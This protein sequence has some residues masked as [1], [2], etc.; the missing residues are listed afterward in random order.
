LAACG[1]DRLGVQ[2]RK[3]ESGQRYLV[4][5]IL[6][7]DLAHFELSENRTGPNPDAGI[8]ITPM[9]DRAGYGRYAGP[10]A[11]GFSVSGTTIET[12]EMRISVEDDARSV[13]VF[14]KVRGVPLTR[15]SG[16]DLDQGTKRLRIERQEIENVYGVGNLFYDPNMA[17]GDWVGRNWQGR[18]HGN[19]RFGFYVSDGATGNDNFHGGGPS[20]SQFPVIYGVGRSLGGGQFQNYCLLLD[21]VYRMSWDFRGNQHWEAR[22]WGDQLR[23]FVMTGPDLKDLRRDF[24]ELTGRPPMPPRNVFGLWIS[25]FGYDNWSEIRTDLDSLKANRFPVDGV[26]LDLQW[27]GGSFDANEADAFCQPDRMGTLEFNRA[28]FPSPETEIPKFLNDYGVRFMTIEESY[29]DNRLPEHAGLWQRKFLAR[30]SDVEPVTVTRDFRHEGQDDHCVW[31][32]RGGMID[33]SNAAAGDYWHQLKRLNLSLMGINAHWLDLGEPEMYYEQALYH[34]FPE[35]GKNRHGDI[36]NLYNLFW[37]ESILRGYRSEEN[38]QRLQEALGLHETPRHFTLSRAG[39]VGSQRYGGMWSG[40][41]GQN[42]GNLRAHLNTQMHMSLAGMDFY[43][44]DAGGFL[45]TGNLGREPGDD[46]QELYTQWF[47]NNALLDIPLR[48][49]AWAYAEQTGNIRIAPDQR[50]HRDS[51][52][53]NLLLRYELTPYLYSLAHEANR[54]GEPIFPP[55]VYQFQADPHVRQIGNV[56]M[57][58]P[59]LLFGVVAGFGQT[60]RR[61]YLPPGCWVDYHALDWYDSGGDE[62]P[63]VSVYRDRQGHEGLFTLPLFARA[64]AIVPLMYVDDKTRN[65]S[66]R[67]DIQ[68]ADLTDEQRQREARL[69]AELRLRVVAGEAPTSFTLFEDDGLTLEYLA[70]KVRTTRIEQQAAGNA[71]RVVIQPAEGT[72]SGAPASRS[73]T[74]ELIVDRREA[75]AVEV[76]GQPLPHVNSREQFDAGMVGWHNAGRNRILA[77]AAERDVTSPTTLV[78]RLSALQ[79]ARTSLHFVCSNGKTQPGESI[80]VVGNIPALGSWNPAEA[81]RLVPVRYQTWFRWARTVGDL[82][83]NA[84]IEW[85]FIRRRESGGEVLQWENDGPNHAVTT[86]AAGFAGTVQGHFQN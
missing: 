65:V 48:P 81:V 47:A 25:E 41:V 61:V 19:F 7:D 59:S 39:T 51:N 50:G 72:F 45:G 64:G 68:L 17:D 60:D 12:R 3:F 28:N 21:Q 86:P 20:V 77:R 16:F 10:T 15:I 84:A 71:V 37:A 70:G 67:R 46:E 36:H 73:A 53:A 57:I 42:L 18:N 66:G 80:Y 38:R 83:P 14:D 1:E 32:G 13:R 52:R 58:G 49:H 62:T 31:W 24:M 27:F 79:P 29:V 9:I 23:W 11:G 75:V 55:L 5:E 85:K 69:A 26:A 43:T 74:V 33:W 44:S 82:P 76:G 35:L 54:G 34:G 2:R 30:V 8:Y 63:S 6:D 40:D 56:K 78:F 22:T 4:V